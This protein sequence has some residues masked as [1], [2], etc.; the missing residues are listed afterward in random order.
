MK[1]RL[2]QLNAW[3]ERWAQTRLVRRLDMTGQ[4]LW[5][6]YLIIALTILIGLTF[7]GATGIGYFV[8]LAE[9]APTYSAEDMKTEIHD[10]EETSEIYFDNDTYLGELPSILHRREVPLDDVSDY[11]TQAMIATEDEYF[12]EH[13]GIVPKAI[14]RASF[15]EIA[16]TGRQTG[17]STLTQQIVKNQLLSNEVSFDRKAREIMVALRLENYIEKE[18]ILEAYLNIVPFGRDASGTQIAGIQ[19]AAQG[20]FGVDAS[21]LNLP[22]AAYLAGMPQNPFSYS[23]FNPDGNVRDNSAAGI[24]RMETVLSRMHENDMID[25]ETYEEALTYDIEQ[26]LTDKSTGKRK[27]LDDYPY[28]T[29]ETE[30][31]ASLILRDVLL[32]ENNVD[33]ST[34]DDETHANMLESYL[35]EAK[36]QLRLGGYRIHTTI[37]QNIYD[38]MNEAI[39]NDNLFGPD[40]GDKP[41][42]IG[43]SLIDNET[44]AV[45]GFVGGRDFERENLNHATQGHRSI[46]ST[47]KPL[48][49]YGSALERGV[50]QPAYLLPDVP[51]T[52]SD[53]TKL[54]NYRDS[55]RGFMSVRDAIKDSQNVPAMKTFQQLDQEDAHADLLDMGFS[56]PDEHLY[57]AT[58][59]GA[60][61]ATVEENTS[62]MSLFGNE[63]TRAE[64]YMIER[65]ETQNGEIIYEHEPEAVDV[66]SPET[67]YLAIDMLRDVLKSGTAQF[68]PAMMNDNGDW[69]GKTGTSD[70]YHDAWFIGLNPRVTLGVWI[71]YDQP[72]PI[73]R[74]FNGHTYSQRV[75]GLWATM[76]NAAADANSGRIFSEDD[77]SAPDGVERETICGINGLLPSIKCHDAGLVSSDLFNEEHLPAEKDDSR[78]ERYVTISGVNYR[79]PEETPTEF[80][81]DG[82]AVDTPFLE[83]IDLN[84]SDGLLGDIILEQEPPVTADP[85]EAV[86]G[87]S[88]SESTLSWAEH[89][90]ANIIGYRIYQSDG[91]Q[92]ASV[93]GHKSTTYQGIG[94]GENYYV[95]AVDT[96]GRESPLASQ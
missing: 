26:H 2:H 54:T 20:V 86:S 64:S 92:V 25:D 36:N 90:D 10:Y 80:T 62:A 46:G 4:V 79:A 45:L 22:Q 21:D 6:L 67:S 18:E 13:S 47:I 34:L 65:I 55:Y 72:Q 7:V 42:E 33:V 17:G 14:M 31:R 82:L 52:Y 69:A 23:P 83:Y 40:R 1:R 73:E 24:K 49:P 87:V 43:A 84:E 60:I 39:D 50:V 57:E 53:G 15:Q 11:V 12:Y 30:R 27:S 8:S 70:D 5:N 19:T 95:T 96:L 93:T 88:A 59:L 76:M 61:D 91:K 37:D 75:Q 44:G 77:F 56:L 74:Q 35:E 3:M 63:G 78:E 58:A 89:P 16:G 41:E 94:E 48:M 68:L 85:P 32:E 71:G 81:K 51:S 38:A 9:N 66:F 28:L 29:D